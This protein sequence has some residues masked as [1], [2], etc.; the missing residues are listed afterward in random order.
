MNSGGVRLQ[1]ANT[2]DASA[3]LAG[4]CDTSAASSHRCSAHTS[5]VR[6]LGVCALQLTAL[7][8][9]F[10]VLTAPAVA[11][12]D[13][14]TVRDQAGTY[15]GAPTWGG[16]QLWTD[17]FIYDQ[18][19]I[20]QNVLTGHY[21]LLDDRDRRRAAGTLDHCRDVFSQLRDELQLP[22]LKPQIVVTI[23]GLGRTR[24][25]MA[26]MG[27]YLANEG[28][29]GWVD[30]GY[31]STR[32]SVAAH[33]AALD[34]V[35]SGLIGVQ[36]V[37]FVAHSLGNLVVRHYLADLSRRTDLPHGYPRIGRIV[38]LAPPNQG[39][40]LARQLKDNVLFEL[41]MGVGGTQLSDD[42][43]ELEPKLAIPNGQF[44]IIAATVGRDGEG[45][46]ALPGADDL[47][48]RVVETRLPGAHDFL[49]VTAPH[50]FLMDSAEARAATLRFLQHGYFLSAEQRQPIPR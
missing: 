1:S 48:V 27:Q 13:A 44:G 7:L 14:E 22:A 5:S 30:M 9:L 12:D 43:A 50:T 17:H 26:G 29:F 23:H 28:E 39:A 11:A 21:R 31:A 25:S 20:Q 41:V 38:M 6:V 19:R 47:L 49:Q 8:G 18:W 24:G 2:C 40:A 46:P 4:R 34:H 33:A 3:E 15:T 32:D 37:H 42:W 35:V 16:T 45:N 36:E 10:S